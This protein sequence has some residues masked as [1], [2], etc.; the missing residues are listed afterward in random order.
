MIISPNFLASGGASHGALAC[1]GRPF[2]VRTSSGLVARL[3][4]EPACC[5]RTSRSSSKYTENC[6][7]RMPKSAT[8]CRSDKWLNIHHH[9][10]GIIQ[11]GSGKMAKLLLPPSIPHAFFFSLTHEFCSRVPWYTQKL[12]KTNVSFRQISKIRGGDEFSKTLHEWIPTVA[13][14]DGWSCGG[15]GMLSIADWDPNMSLYDDVSKLPA[16]ERRKIGA[17]G[18]CTRKL[19]S[20]YADQSCCAAAPD[21][22]P[23]SSDESPP[24]ARI[25][26]EVTLVDPQCVRCIVI[27]S[28]LHSGLHL[29]TSRGHT[30][31]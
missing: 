18:P 16:C 30:R 5:A 19:H 10:R 25:G 12:V 21:H 9:S 1:Q 8:S 6:R 29:R 13:M 3:L 28:I 26:H 31:G 20:V 15:I 23:R 24:R 27:P 11:A 22:F 4:C 17:H 7:N 2:G 14:L